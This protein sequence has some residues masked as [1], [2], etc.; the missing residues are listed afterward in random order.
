LF[1]LFANSNLSMTSTPRTHFFYASNAAAAHCL[2][3]YIDQS[4]PAVQQ[5][6]LHGQT[7]ALAAPGFAEATHDGK[8]FRDEEALNMVKNT[9]ADALQAYAR[10][11]KPK[12]TFLYDV[13]NEQDAALALRIR[14]SAP[15]LCVQFVV[16]GMALPSPVAC[17]LHTSYNAWCNDDARNV[18]KSIL[19]TPAKK[20]PAASFF[21]QATGSSALTPATADASSTAA[22]MPAAQTP[23]TAL[24][25]QVTPTAAE[26][27]TPAAQ[28][29]TPAAE[30]LTQVAPT[31]AAEAPTP[32]AEAL[33]QV[34]PT[35]AAQ[36]P[37]PAAQ[38]PTPTPAAAM[39]LPTAYFVAAREAMMVVPA[40]FAADSVRFRMYVAARERAQFMEQL[41]RLPGEWMRRIAVVFTP[42]SVTNTVDCVDYWHVKRMYAEATRDEVM[43]VLLWQP[44]Q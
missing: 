9:L 26:A 19:E 1:I 43:K 29:P 34:A 4:P 40:S 2:A 5:L 22:Q 17:T 13:N 16:Q 18:L 36:A 21:V 11:N 14:F 6:F 25:T 23:A 20:N 30:A 7:W 38:A 28:A 42:D 3:A 32:A 31:P 39:D 10:A 44:A 37:T 8:L 12:A 15:A 27:L 24:P 33:T 41:T 35:P